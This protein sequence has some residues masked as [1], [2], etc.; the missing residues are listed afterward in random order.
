MTG[1]VGGKKGWAVGVGV[2]TLFSDALSWWKVHGYGE[3]KKDISLVKK[4][5]E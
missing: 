1:S 5:D 4:E 2:D 3:S